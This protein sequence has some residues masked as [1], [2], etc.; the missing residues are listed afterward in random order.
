MAPAHLSDHRYS[1]YEI[2]RS[3]N[4]NVTKEDATK[5]MHDNIN[6][7]RALD[8]LKRM[9]VAQGVDVKLAEELCRQDL[10][11]VDEYLSIMGQ[12]SDFHKEI[13]ATKDGM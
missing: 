7:G 10:R 4:D 5:L 2:L 11:S 3:L 12:K 8:H 6:N 13:L 9:L 1:V